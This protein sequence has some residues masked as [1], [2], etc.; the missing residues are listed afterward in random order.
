MHAQ[1]GGGGKGGT[2]KPPFKNIKKNK[3]AGLFLNI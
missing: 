3:I 1:G 2:W